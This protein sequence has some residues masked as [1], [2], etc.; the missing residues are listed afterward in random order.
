MYARKL[1]TSK[2]IRMLLYD[3]R[4]RCTQ[5]AIVLF[6]LSNFLVYFYHKVP[7]PPPPTKKKPAYDNNTANSVII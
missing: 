7:R 4:A 5:K 3:V 6:G 2:C 1:Y